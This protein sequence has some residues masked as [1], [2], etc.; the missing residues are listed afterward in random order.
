[1]KPE[2][3]S[4]ST[5]KKRKETEEDKGDAEEFT[6]EE[7]K[8]HFDKPIYVAAANLKT[9]VADIKNSYK[10]FGMKR[11]PFLGSTKVRKRTVVATMLESADAEQKSRLTKK[12][13]EAASEVNIQRPRRNAKKKNI[14]RVGSSTDSS[15]EFS[16]VNSASKDAFAFSTSRIDTAAVDVN[17]AAAAAAAD[18]AGDDTEISEETQ[19]N[20]ITFENSLTLKRPQK[21]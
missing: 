15:A 7:L 16:V 4:A 11:W 19:R 18:A 3:S 17:Y 10:K 6:Y 14:D 12:I 20:T 21:N 8:Q 13:K 5:S 2:K 1:M 9:Q